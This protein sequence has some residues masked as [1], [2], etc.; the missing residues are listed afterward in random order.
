MGHKPPVFLGTTNMLDKVNPVQKN[1]IYICT[2]T[3]ICNVND[4]NASSGVREKVI[5][6]NFGAKNG[7]KI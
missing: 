7:G 5:L 6:T 3:S 4:K 2:Q 1:R